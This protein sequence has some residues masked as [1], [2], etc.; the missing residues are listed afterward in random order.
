MSTAHTAIKIVLKYT[1][2]D[3]DYEG[4]D[5]VGKYTRATIADAVSFN[6]E[7]Q[8]ANHAT[9]TYM[10]SEPKKIKLTIEEL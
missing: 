4:M 5:F 9:F 10:K 6:T 3:P 7:E 1:V 2:K 8:A